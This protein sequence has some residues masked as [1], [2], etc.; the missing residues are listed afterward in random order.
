M[1]LYDVGAGLGPPLRRC[2]GERFGGCLL[3]ASPAA[4]SE[5]STAACMGRS[6]M[7]PHSTRHPC[8]HK[9]SE[10]GASKSSECTSGVV[11]SYLQVEACIGQ[12]AAHA[13]MWQ[14]LALGLQAGGEGSPMICCCALLGIYRRSEFLSQLP[15]ACSSCKCRS[16]WAP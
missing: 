4:M 6:L 12:E 7:F 9:G 13:R 3:L 15:E 10:Y 8:S 1:L 14:L 16:P 2:A 5:S 11:Q